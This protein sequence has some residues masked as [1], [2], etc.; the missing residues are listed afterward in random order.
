M[1]N[2][3]KSEWGFILSTRF[4]AIVIGAVALALNQEGLLA[5]SYMIAIT[6]IVGGFTVVRTID[7]QGDKKVEAAIKG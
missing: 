4:W 7:R 6:T 5:D 3:K 1:D 2:F